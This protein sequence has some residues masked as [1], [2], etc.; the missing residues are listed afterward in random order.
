MYRIRLT[1]VG[2][3]HIEPGGFI[4]VL[5]ACEFKP[6]VVG[7]PVAVL[8]VADHDD[9]GLG[10]AFKSITKDNEVVLAFDVLDHVVKAEDNVSAPTAEG[11]HALIVV[12]DLIFYFLNHVGLGVTGLVFGID[13][14]ELAHTGEKVINLTN[15]RGRSVSRYDH[16]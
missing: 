3:V 11:D 4:A 16:R 15:V 1:T 8:V 7:L 14:D 13:I 2:R 9:T 5:G 10:A 12:G 6:L